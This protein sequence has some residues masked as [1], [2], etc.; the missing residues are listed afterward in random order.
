MGHINLNDLNKLLIMW[1]Y[2]MSLKNQT[3]I[4]YSMDIEWNSGFAYLVLRLINR[5]DKLCILVILIPNARL[6]NMFKWNWN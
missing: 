1:H 2:L 3:L 4:K 5:N 6:G